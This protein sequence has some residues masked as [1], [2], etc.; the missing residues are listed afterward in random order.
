MV[1]MELMLRDEVLLRES[2]KAENDSLKSELL[3]CQT[4]PANNLSGLSSSQSKGSY[5]RLHAKVPVSSKSTSEQDALRELLQENKNLRSQLEQAAEYNLQLEGSNRDL[6]ESVSRLSEENE[7]I[8]TLNIQFI[9]EKNQLEG[10][11]RQ[12]LDEDKLDDETIQK[13]F[14][15]L[16]NLRRE[17]EELYDALGKLGEEQVS[18]LQ[19]E[20]KT[21]E[22]QVEKLHHQLNSK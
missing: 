11:V 18:K 20:L 1:E 14:T 9:E 16:D 12:L 3:V 2:L 8:K 21:R 5:V 19:K 22:E 15:S 17:N 4:I 7:A 13:L 6:S 10:K